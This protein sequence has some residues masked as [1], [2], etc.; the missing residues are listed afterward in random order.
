M[1]W[2][3]VDLSPR[4]VIGA[5]L[6]DAQLR[7]GAGTGRGLDGRPPG[8][9]PAGPAHAAIS[10]HVRHSLHLMVGFTARPAPVHRGACA[11]AVAA[12]RCGVDMCMT[13]SLE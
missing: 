3:G 7:R 5:R 6:P 11:A 1:K 2:S 13:C 9:S 10:S 12:N 8:W 4:I